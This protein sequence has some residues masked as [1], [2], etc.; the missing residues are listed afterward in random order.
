MPS[1]ERFGEFRFFAQEP[2]GKSR[3]LVLVT[4]APL[5]LYQAGI[6]NAAG[7][8]QS[9]DATQAVVRSLTGIVARDIGVGAGKPNTTTTATPPAAGEHGAAELFVEVI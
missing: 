4:T 3:V 6:G 5:N 8:F 7:I 2:K 1:I 9:F